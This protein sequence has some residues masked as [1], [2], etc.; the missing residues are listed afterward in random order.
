MTLPPPPSKQFLLSTS[1]TFSLRWFPASPPG[2]EVERKERNERWKRK[3]Q[4]PGSP[5]GSLRPLEGPS[6]THRLSST[7]QKP[8]QTAKT[9]IPGLPSHHW[10]LSG[11]SLGQ[12]QACQ[13][14]QQGKRLTKVGIFVCIIHIC[15][16]KQA[17]CLGI[18]LNEFK[19]I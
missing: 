10:P 15:Y 12:L 17:I 9:S 13:S 6:V 7:C 2:N 14:V 1:I 18:M 19:D 16:K 3:K 4:R 5:E 8:Q 11:S